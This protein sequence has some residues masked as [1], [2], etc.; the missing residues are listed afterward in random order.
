MSFAGKRKIA[1]IGG[2]AAG[3]MAALSASAHGA[4]VTV[5]EHTDSIGKKILQTG[6][7]KC[8]FTNV[9][10]SADK[11][12]TSGDR[13]FIEKILDHFG[14]EDAIRFMSSIG[15]YTKNR[16]GGLYPYTETAATVLD[17]LRMELRKC[18]VRVLLKCGDVKIGNE[19]SVNG[20][21]YDAVIIAAGS[22]AAPKTGSDGSGYKIAK[23]LGITI[24]RPVPALTPLLLED[25]VRELVGIRCDA[26]LTLVYGGKIID[27]SKGELQPV[28]N[29][30]SGIC[31]LDISANAARLIC[32]GKRAELRADFF[33]DFDDNTFRQF[34]EYRIKQYPDRNINEIFAG[35]FAK[36]LAVFL[37]RGTDC[38]RKD[39]LDDLIE[40]VKHHHFVIA[41]GQCDD[42]SRAQTVSG[43]IPLE[44]FTD[45]CMLKKSSGIYFA[46]EIMDADGVCGGYN[47][48]WAWSTG[49]AAGIGAAEGI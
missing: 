43:G 42:F 37:L 47:L 40:N 31:A 25:D 17:I 49:Y 30:F 23:Q 39:F 27:Q 22:N 6:N 4:D 19:P 33:P 20:E 41:Q 45:C 21:K 32:S 26:E 38:R 10:M 9:I 15:I 18:G 35:L 2:G 12:H 5:F 14:N 34:I 48:Q 36:K 11:Y 24:I 7:G 16:K 28:P 44:E 46:G 13:M 29:G 3:I 8:N 1:V